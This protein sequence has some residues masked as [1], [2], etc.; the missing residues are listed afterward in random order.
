MSRLSTQHFHRLLKARLWTT[1]NS[2]MLS[3]CT[4]VSK[5]RS[6]VHLLAR[7]RRLSILRHH[8]TGKNRASCHQSIQQLL[9]LSTVC[10]RKEKSNHLKITT[11]KR[12][13][14][15]LVFSLAEYRKYFSGY[16]VAA[17]LRSLP[18][19]PRRKQAFRDLREWIDKYEIADSTDV[20]YLS[21]SHWIFWQVWQK[22]FT[23]N[24]Y[25]IA[26][27]P[28]FQIVKEYGVVLQMVTIM[29]KKI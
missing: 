7:R 29:M 11:V 25:T 14:C 28:A 13:A 1:K 10:N 17:T 20:Q 21:N 6:A 2:K 8:Q 26:G 16:I 15:S 3:K 19:G 18:R 9:W 27:L 4:A 23:C 22:N 5:K 12:C 24:I